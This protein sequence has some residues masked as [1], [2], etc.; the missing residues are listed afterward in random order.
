MNS[1]F[2]FDITSQYFAFP[3]EGSEM[4]G[5]RLVAAPLRA[6]RQCGLVTAVSAR[7]DTP[8]SMAPENVELVKRLYEAFS[9]GDNAWP[10][11]VYEP[12]IEWD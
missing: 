11:E 9:T 6:E 1:T 12:D 10:F 4:V 3:L 2:S 8:G 5:C 7:S